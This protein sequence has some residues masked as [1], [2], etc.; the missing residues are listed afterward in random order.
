MMMEISLEEI[1]L[2]F[3]Q[4]IA[5]IISREEIA[6]WANT[7]IREGDNGK[8]NYAPTITKKKFENH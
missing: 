6:D 7:R 3:N 1:K 4:L 5:Q 2:K 8:L